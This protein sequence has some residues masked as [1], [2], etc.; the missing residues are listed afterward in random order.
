MWPKFLVHRAK[1]R[2]TKLTQYLIRKQRLDA[3]A[4]TQLAPVKK[5]VERR[6]R[7]REQRA[8]D[9]AKLTM[10]IERELLERLK[11]GKYGEIFNFAQKEFEHVMEREAEP[12]QFERDL[13]DGYYKPAYQSSDGDDGDSGHEDALAIT[14]DY[15]DG[16]MDDHEA[17]SDESAPQATWYESD[18]EASSAP[19]LEDLS[20]TLDKKSTPFHFDATSDAEIDEPGTTR[21]GTRYPKQSARALS[22]RRNSKQRAPKRRLR[23]EQEFEFEQEFERE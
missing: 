23:S 5:K 1:Q 12:F 6:E 18:S 15:P 14:T 19:D 9:A 13:E 4:K 20:R 10:T 17:S 8:L 7:K 11:Q 2:L 21:T 3:V 22:K 16:F